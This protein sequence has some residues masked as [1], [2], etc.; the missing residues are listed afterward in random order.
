MKDTAMKQ[1]IRLSSW[2]GCA[3]A[4]L[5]LS[6]PLMF[7]V[8]GEGTQPKR[9]NIVWVVGENFALDL[10]CYGAK[11]VLT[12]NLDSLAANGVRYTRVYSTS[13]VCAPS[14]SA[15]MTGMYQTS[16]DTHNMRSHR[17]DDFRLPAGVRPITHLSLIHI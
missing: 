15:F 9:P 17:E 1:P 10:G 13:P 12:P 3:V 7:P 11:N 14:R 2:S 5:L 4:V 8:S 16:T 6:A